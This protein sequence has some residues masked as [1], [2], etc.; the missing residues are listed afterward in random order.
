MHRF[1]YAQ[2]PRYAALGLAAAFAVLAL[3][4][5]S[6]GGTPAA[7][8]G[9]A[10]KTAAVKRHYG[11]IVFDP[12][13]LSSAYAAGTI[14]AQ[15]ATFKV[16]ENHA[17]P[18]GRTIDLHIAW[19]PP[20]D[21]SAVDDDPV[22]FL[23]GGPGQAATESWPLVDG[24]FREVRKHR[25][26]VLVDQRGTGRSTPLTCRDAAGDSD[27]GQS[28]QAMLDHSVAAVER[29][30]KSLKV[31]ARY[32][33]TTDAIADLDLV[34]TAIGAA[35][36]D[37]V[38]VSYGTRVAQQYAGRYPQHTRA[39]VLDG[40]APNELVLGSEHARNLDSA[41]AAQFK[42]CQQTPACRARF[43]GEPREQLRRLMARLQAAPVEVDYRDP[44]TGEQLREKVTS[45]HV[46]ML[47]RM[48]SYAP[49]A[50]SLLPL[51]LNEADQGRYAP[52]MSLSKMLG[53]QLSEELN[54]G[55][56]LSVTC[57]EDADLFVADPAD[58]DTVLGDAMTKVLQAQ[59][60][61]W[62]TG[63]RPKDFH[64]P[65]A[66]PLPVLLLSGELDPVTPPRYGEQVLKHLPNGRH[67]ILRGQGHGALRIGCTPKLLGQ[68][69]ETANAKQ[70][71][72]RCLDAL[73]YVPPFVSFNGW[74]P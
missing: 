16:P 34:R 6:N 52:L 33:T 60:K 51:M 8:S 59:C 62:P 4:G 41:L 48:F 49:E 25:S 38:G 9:G 30:A 36:I 55:M 11:R 18:N 57:A 3:A 14:A 56:Q 40:V 61:V 31:D 12:C 10:G 27:G 53:N 29:C 54:Y 7:A 63:Q 2:R 17:A 50:A 20:T 15:C 37:L 70:L 46:A 58:A 45:G 43:G 69:I 66:S 73:G 1:G 24:A 47:T 74:E 28:E 72:A 32:F 71:D 44:S 19:L 5:C 68:F 39:V 42:L 26:I 13:T 35:K 22:F 21:E 67:L 23:A 64:A 65:F